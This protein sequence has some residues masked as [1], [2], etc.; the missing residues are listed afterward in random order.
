MLAR[1]LDHTGRGV[2]LTVL[3]AAA[4]V[5]GFAVASAVGAPG[6]TRLV[7]VAGNDSTASASAQPEKASK[8]EKTGP[9]SDEAD[10]VHGACVAKVAHDKSAVG[11]P[12]H[13]HGW[14]V[15]RAAHSCPHPSSAATDD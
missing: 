1:L 14:A 15:S 6:P 7:T 13:N 2:R 8:S 11:G 4:L 5:A 3:L 10:G 9:G 12:Q